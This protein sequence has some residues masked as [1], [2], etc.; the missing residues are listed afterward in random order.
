MRVWNVDLR[1]EG[2]SFG[3]FAPVDTVKRLF[4]LEVK[5]GLSG[6]IVGRSWTVASEIA[7]FPKTVGD[8]FHICPQWFIAIAAV[9]MGIKVCLICPG[10]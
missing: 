6:A 3:A 8:E 2:L 9:V 5:I 10:N 7:C 1:V 4:A